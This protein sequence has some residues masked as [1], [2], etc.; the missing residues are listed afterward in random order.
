[1]LLDQAQ[2][3][4]GTGRPQPGACLHCHTSIIPFYASVGREKLGAGAARQEAIRAGFEEV[5]GWTYQDA[6]RR[7][8]KFAAGNP[9]QTGGKAHPVSCVDCHDATTMEMRVTRPGFLAGIQAF[10]ASE[11]P[12]PED[13]M[14][15][16]PQFPSIR[17]WRQRNRQQPY[18]PNRDAVRSE[19]RSFVCGQCH[20]EYYFRGEHKTLTYPWYQGLKVEE[21]ESYYDDGANFPG[22]KPHVDFVN[23]ETGA[24]V[25]KAQ[26]PEF[27]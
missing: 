15:S 3:R 22:G 6:H 12:M 20:V 13:K 9:Q 27:E 8:E 10:A 4:R 5:S 17:R 24:P 16:L 7:M 19:M 21:I 26:H 1:M 2:T 23:A 18:D 25:L 11:P 14:A